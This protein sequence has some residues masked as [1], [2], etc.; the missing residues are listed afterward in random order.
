MSKS[1]IAII[2]AALAPDFGIGLKGGLPWRLKQEMKYFRA[3]TSY[4]SQPN[5]KN[6]VIMGRKTWESIPKKFRPLPD[7]VNVILSRSHQGAILEDGTILVESLDAAINLLQDQNIDK[8]YIIG[9]AQIYNQI[10]N[11]ERL[12][13]VLLTEI[14]S[15]QPVEMDTFI[16]FD[17]SKWEKR[18]LADLKAFVGETFETEI[19]ENVTEGDYQYRY[20]MWTR[21]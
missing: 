13:H 2:V 4:S 11:D 6:A 21:K 16:D 3:V 12:T 7:R 18:S 10:L 15:K 17:T 14:E 20:T 5:L 19:P 1:P 8:I 9:G